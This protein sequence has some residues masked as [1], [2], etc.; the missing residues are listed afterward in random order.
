MLPAV[1]ILVFLHGTA[2]M[3]PT[4]AGRP[5]AERVRQSQQ[6]DRA[7]LDFA[8][9]VPTEAAVEK[10]GTWQ[11]HGAVI[12]YLSSHTTAAGAELD[13]AVLARHGFPAG[14]M[15]FRRPGESY[16]A[17]T[18]RAA[19][20]V[21]VEDDRESIGGRSQT[22]AA[23]LAAAP[24]DAVAC[25]IVPEFGG[26]AHLPDNPTQLATTARPLSGTTHEGRP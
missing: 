18:R 4:A 11:R 16:A 10:V 22:T 9:Y 1:R 6:R 2:I 8:A 17:V 23:S 21:V 24:G 13:R 7:V 3:H 12:C 26:L 20:D 14:T 25:V 15:F 5:R 19:A